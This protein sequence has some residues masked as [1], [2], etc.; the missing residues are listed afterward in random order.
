MSAPN[1]IRVTGERGET[2][3]SRDVCCYQVLLWELWPRGS[4]RTFSPG[5]WQVQTLELERTQHKRLLESLQQR[6]Q[7]DLALL[8]TAHRYQALACSP[9]QCH[10]LAYSPVHR[11]WGGILGCF[12]NPSLGRAGT[13]PC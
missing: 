13:E 5:A 12:L 11:P 6:H 1:S 7:E 4:T 9:L 8:E 3:L 2:S 10:V